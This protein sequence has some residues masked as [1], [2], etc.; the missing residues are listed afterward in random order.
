M[1]RDLYAY[2]GRLMAIVKYCNKNTGVTYVYESES[3]WDKEKKQPRNR[4]KIIGK[5]DPVTGEIVPTGK[6]GRTKKETDPDAE[7]EELKRLQDQLNACQEELRETKLQM[8]LQSVKI[9]K[10][11]TELKAAKEEAEKLL[12]ILSSAQ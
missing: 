5:I 9:K 1:R 6:K 3:C 7:S 4:R 2:G 8:D 12:S 10:L 11:E